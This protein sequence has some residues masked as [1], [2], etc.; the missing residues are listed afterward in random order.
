[1]SKN[2]NTIQSVLAA[3]LIMG[4]ILVYYHFK[5][6]NFKQKI[7]ANKDLTEGR[8]IKCEYLNKHN[9][10]VDYT[11]QTLNNETVYGYVNGGEYRSLRNV[12]IGKVFPIVYDSTYPKRNAI[13]IFPNSFKR[14][15][16]KFP[17]SLNWVLSYLDN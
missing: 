10:V 9:Y 4:G 6:N 8:V 13:L 16:I 11:F 12:I 5:A 2:K 3:I 1:M 15:E 17:D 7:L 14:Y